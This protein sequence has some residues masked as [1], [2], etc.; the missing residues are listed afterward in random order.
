MSQKDTSTIFS[1]IVLSSP[2]KISSQTF[3]IRQYKFKTTSYMLKNI[4]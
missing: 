1:D 3:T 4:S 2:T